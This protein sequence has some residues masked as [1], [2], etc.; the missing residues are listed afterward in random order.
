MKAKTAMEAARLL[1]DLKRTLEHAERLRTAW[2]SLETQ[3]TS[4][5]VVF[6]IS[7]GVMDKQ[8]WEAARG[9]AVAALDRKAETIK[10][11]LAKLG[12]G[13]SAEDL[14]EIP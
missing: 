7:M 14:K 10:S 3:S 11:Q 13:S 8:T 5:L 1:P 4:A 2:Y 9:V 6:D 12:V